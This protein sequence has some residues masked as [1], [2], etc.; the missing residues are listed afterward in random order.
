MIRSIGFITF[1]LA[2]SSFCYGEEQYL[3]NDSDRHSA[4]EQDQ[5][6]VKGDIWPNLLELDDIDVANE[7][8]VVALPNSRNTQ[9][10]GVTASEYTHPF[11]YY[12]LI[13]GPPQLS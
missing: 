7:H 2:L 1:L 4:F 5:H 11:S 8:Q 9:D 12:L 6:L 13:R 10:A 3:N